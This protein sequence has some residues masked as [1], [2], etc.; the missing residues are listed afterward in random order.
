MKKLLLLLLLPIF[1]YAQTPPP[2]PAP[3]T[4]STSAQE[5]FGH[6]QNN[7]IGA[8]SHSFGGGSIIKPNPMLT[9]ASFAMMQNATYE[10]GWR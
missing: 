2:A 10:G 3:A 4:Q 6:T 5:D 9:S 8:Q 7:I 1:L